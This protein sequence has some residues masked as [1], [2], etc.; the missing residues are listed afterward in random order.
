MYK[1]SNGRSKVFGR[2]LALGM[3]AMMAA[4]TIATATNSIT[5]FAQEGDNLLNSSDVVF[6]EDESGAESSNDTDSSASTEKSDRASEDSSE[7]VLD[8]E[9]DQSLEEGSEDEALFEDSLDDAL[10]ELSFEDASEET[11]DETSDEKA[12][13]LLESKALLTGS[14]D[15]VIA[16]QGED[17][18]ENFTEDT[19]VANIKFG[20]NGNVSSESVYSQENG[21][22]FSDVDYSQAATG[23]SN[24]VYYP[25][26]PAVSAGAG[27]VVDAENYVAIASKIWTETESTGYG[28]YTY[29]STS[30]FDV[31]LY[32]ADYKVAVTFVNPTD[33]DYTAALEAEDITKV[34]GINVPA[35][36]TV[37]Q[38]FEANLVDGNLNIKFLGTSDAKSMNDAKTTK[39]YV[40]GVKITRLATQER[41]DKPTIFI[42][43]DSTVQ[44]YDEYYYPQTGWGQVLSTY[45]GDLVEERECDTCG[46]SQSQTYETTNA[47]VENRSIGGRSSKSF[48]DE[49]KFDDIL[50]D[51]KPGDYL[52]VQWGHNDATYSRP[53]R[54]VS[55][56]DFEK[57]MMVYV[58][59]ALERGVT[60]VFVTPVARYSYTTNSD[61]S[62]NS[63]ASNFEAYRQVM[64]RLAREY[65]VPY[66][67]LTQRSI[68]VCNNFGIEGS[69]MLFLKLAA[70]EVSGGAYAG[71][72]DDSTHL[73]YYGALKFAQCVAEGIVDYANGDV[74]N[75]TDA[76]DSLASLVEVKKA[77]QAPAQVT[78]LKTTSVGA[79]SI[80]LEWEASEGSELY[81]IYRAALSDGQTIDDVVF[82]KAVKYSV[83]GKTSYVDNNCAGGVTYVY[84][85]GGFN[86]YGVGEL[87]EKIAVSTKTAGLRFDFNYNNSPTMEG[88]TGVNQ[89][90]MYDAAKGY[91]WKT[92]PNN[93]RYR[94][95]NG[96]A[97]SSAMADDFNLG[98]GEFAVD[99]PNGT[100]EVTV[101]AGDLLDG[102][103]TIKPA[104]SAEGISIG[105]IACKQS[106]GS[107][108]GTVSITDGQL[109][110]TVE[111]S[112]Q[113]ING[114]TVTSLL[115]APGN[116]AITELSFER[117]TA[118]FLL[119][120]TKVEDAVSYRVYQK[121]ESD[122]DFNLVKSYSAQE[123]IDNELDCRAMSATLGE[124]YSY[125]M[126]CLVAD[127]TESAKSNIVSQSMLDPNVA[128]PTA[129]KGLK[130]TS[131]EDGQE[132]LQ[133]TI[134]LAWDE[135]P[136]SENVIK[137]VIYRSAKAESDKGFKEFVKV[138]ESD[139]NTYTDEDSEIATNVHYYY[140]VAAM[141][142]GG[143]GEQSEAIA[144]P[145]A[146]SLVAGGLETYASRALVAINLAG[147][148]GAETKISATDAE[149]NPITSGVYLSWRSF[150]K[151]FSG[152]E[153][154]T[155]FDVFRNGEQIA[156]GLKVTNLV[157]EAGSASDTYRV[158]GSNDSS[159]GLNS[160]DTSVWANQYM[161]FALNKPEDETMP[162]GSTCTYTANDMSVGD[163]DGDGELELIVKWYP[164]NAK[165]NSGSG[166]TGKTFLDGY[167]VNFSTGAVKQ[168]WRIDLGVNIRSGAH[169][170]Q[171]QVWDFDA[172]GIAEIAVKTA[173]GTTTYTNMDGE[174]VE[175]GYVGACNSDALPTDTISPKYDYR[176]SGG[177]VLDGPEYFSMF[178]G[179]TGELIDTVDYLPAR[180]SVSAWGDGYG[181]RVDRFLSATAYL[182][183]TTPF[184]VFARGYY[185][186]TALTAYYLT[187]TT[188]DEGNEVEQI[189]V[190]WK[191]DTDNIEGGSAYTAQGNHGLSVNDVDGDGKDE[192]IYGSLTLDND[193]TVLYSTGLG[194][195]D[196]MHVSDWI[197]SRPGLEVMGVHEHDNAAYHVEIHDAETGEIITGYYTGK[198]T[199]RGMASDI[200]PTAEG[201]EYWSIANPNY[202]GNDEPSWDSRNAD[203]F[204]SLSGKVG[205]SDGETSSMISLS[206]GATPA[207]NFS[208]YWDGDLLAETQDHTFNS[209]A[210]APLTTTIEKWDYEN[211]TSIK[212]M[213]SDQVLTS[214]GTKGNLGLVADIL[215]DWRDEIIARCSADNSKIRIYSTTIQ[216]DYVIPC[217]LTDLAYREGVAW[218][219]V[220][221][222]QPAH[223]SYLISEGLITA[224]LS[225][226][227]M[228]SNSATLNFT[229]AND[230]V[231]GHK[232]EGY[233]VK[234]ADVTVDEN[235]NQTV[236]DYETVAELDANGLS[237]KEAS[238][239]AKEQ[240]IVGY[241]DGAAIKNF[242][243]GY[244][245]GNANGF[246]RVLADDYSDVNGYGWATGTGSAVNWNRV[247]VGIENAGDTQTDVEKACCD[248]VRADN[249]LKFL[250][251]VP[252]GAYKVD[253]Y[254]GAAYNNNAYNGTKI[255]VNGE[256]LGVVSQSAKV[257][258]IVKTTY[259][260]FDSSSQIEVISSNAGNLAILN[261]I[262]VS[263][264]TPIYG[265]AQEEE[266]EPSSVYSFTDT[267]LKGGSFYSYKI[268]SVVDGKESFASAPL[269][270][271]TTVAIDKLN[272]ELTDM[273]LVQD[274]PLADGQSVADLL[275]AKKQFIS[276]TDSEGVEQIVVIT[277]DASEVDLHTPGEY[278]AHAYIRGY[279]SNPVDVTVKVVA[280]VPTGYAEIKDI[281]VILGNEVKLPSV[282]QAT[283]LNGTTKDVAVTWNTDK[284]DVNKIGDYTL[285]GSVDGTEDTVEIT[286]HIVGDYVVSAADS[287]AEIEYLNKNF[288]LPSKVTVTYASG[289][290]AAADVTWNTSDIDVASL[291]T[292]YNVEGTVADFDGVVNL[293]ATVKYPSLYKF[294][295]GI[296][297]S[298]IAEGWTGVTVNPKKG[299][300]EIKDLGSAYSKD[301]GYGFENPESKMEGRTEE[302]TFD[303][304]LPWLVYTDFALPG[305]ETFLVDVENGKYQVE[306]LSNSVYKSDVSGTV[307]G[308]NFKVGNAANT[309][310]LAAVECE[311][312]DGQLTVSFGNGTYRMG[313]LVVRKAITDASYYGPVEPDEPEVP[314]G[315]FVTKWGTTYY[316]LE[317]ST[318]YTGMLTVDG[319][320]YYFKSNGAMVKQ[321]YVTTEDGKYY[322]DANGHM[323]TGFMTKWGAVYYFDSEGKMVTDSI[324]ALED[325]YKYYV[326]AKGQLVKQNYVTID[327]NT[328]YFDANGYMA[329]GFVTKW[330]TT[331]YF[332]ENGVQLFDTVVEVDGYKYYLNAKGAVV[333]SN[334]VDFEDGRHYFDSEGHMVIGRTITKWT[335]KYTFDENGVLV[336]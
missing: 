196:A 194:H 283:F 189:G 192:I 119:S 319:Y 98:A 17:G 105:S 127:G 4:S 112:N 201:A 26:V 3:S 132:E 219:N 223:T 318:K 267:E 285:K 75:T 145:I 262:V 264:A 193:G 330:G 167:D 81:Y 95:G 269:T 239:G 186:R 177:Y 238:G 248:L 252:A 334:F 165:D 109:N 101:Y 36:A 62:L 30:T 317:D 115:P 77:T 134:S 303:G 153:L 258:D 168:L 38:E 235:G 322:F 291:G 242:D 327:G 155:T 71:G 293:K 213:E 34:S 99:L 31:D 133:N 210:Y 265:E 19:V 46:Y 325:G 175:T 96:K 292:T 199:G 108:T 270:V 245:S 84:A 61:G 140:K 173:D 321:D 307:E 309:Y 39:V 231:Y 1:G 137:Y 55:A 178:K 129:V 203:V 43:S 257:A 229:P 273:E 302:F 7:V 52:L 182:N 16:D 323:V 336:N 117:T 114:L 92:A 122:K 90:E 188:D 49:G 234:R 169:Y 217:S 88:W 144:T 33:S 198:D 85:I 50:E 244:K 304:E 154:T 56:D 97:D 12:A 20:T 73:Q 10:E 294:D 212:L 53:N 13:L 41:G 14:S 70:G 120:F 211:Q 276:V 305:N 37:T 160:V 113:Y 256:D 91:G 268:A 216:T 104:Y 313:A 251:D 176:N 205:K 83:S 102:T 225:E 136:A 128:V 69:K 89:N 312:T 9:T 135:S 118:T 247:G 35:G 230:G 74:E 24:N 150:P 204:G 47:I 147:D 295:F 157:D 126:T 240:V 185:T 78:G 166:Y 158:V 93:G 59:G 266:T 308:V 44:T 278:T 260:V 107:C 214:N 183:G 190:Y 65:N 63:F 87:S 335:H 57:W 148:A 206:H 297:D 253:V 243:M 208:L 64:L 27:N 139:N 298:R 32:N 284:L 146:G 195:G 110:V 123:L 332:D 333:K 246:V 159:L 164:S 48:I 279:S 174:L 209:A 315:E 29:E 218:Q 328:Y 5:A 197:P 111:G 42:A 296:S 76:L 255:Y 316:V 181:N 11:I 18:Y 25:R 226:E 215:G 28:V 184:A 220:G 288:E 282:V 142:A 191:F 151:D 274:T 138:G 311:V 228:D 277:W 54:Y 171:F 125:Y 241:T 306:I 227:K 179:N 299:N 314:V 202:M 149:G 163:L 259:V 94:G 68:E 207:V 121:G 249:E 130:C 124:T 300:K 261:A 103:S 80:S 152:K 106:L 172:D 162:D 222:N 310:T 143:I 254:A 82:D 232:V 156:S 6:F 131:P 237:S 58:N 22:G 271:Q 100:Y 272:E 286:V 275:A 15:G 221:Y 236:G 200:D 79:T 326:N 45:F 290:T 23:W 329:T 233:V 331:Y 281:R 66:V 161:E 263:A 180:G 8:E 224:Q 324:I 72:V 21:Y 67:D 86:S 187:K 51:M 2:S 289:A 287:Y 60:P 250:I 280:N 40:S 301:K 116:L 170:T 320:T 141:N